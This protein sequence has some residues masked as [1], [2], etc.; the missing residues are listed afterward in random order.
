MSE[1]PIERAGGITLAALERRGVLARAP[2]WWRELAQRG[3]AAT[4]KPTRPAAARSRPPVIGWLAGVCCPGVSKPCHGHVDGLT[5]PEQFTGNAWRSMLEQLRSGEIEVPLRLE[6]DGPVLATTRSLDLVFTMNPVYGLE[7]EAR[8]RDTAAC[9][10]VLDE[11]SPTGWGV[12][13]GFKRGKQW[14][15]E[16]AGVGRVRVIDDAVLDHVAIIKGGEHRRAA[17]PAAR[18]HAAR[19]TA[20]SCPRKLTDDVHGWAFRILAMQAGAIR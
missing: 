11:I 1:L 20:S 4:A 5:L 10:R 19:A 9:R 18:C 13:I 7:F 2:A 17:Y 15:V 6:H 16:R 14:T 12:S 8:L 3:G